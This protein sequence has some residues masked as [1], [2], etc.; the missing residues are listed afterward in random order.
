MMAYLVDVWVNLVGQQVKA[1]EFVCEINPS[2]GKGRGA[3]RYSDE[4]LGHVA[5]HALDPVRRETSSSC[6]KV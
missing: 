3:F 1:G 5:A 4:Y 2:N 6:R